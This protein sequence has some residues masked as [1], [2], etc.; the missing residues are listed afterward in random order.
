M[1]MA[2][3]FNHFDF[4]KDRKAGLPVSEEDMKS[5]NLF[6]VQMVLSMDNSYIDDINDINTTEF[7]RLPKK[8]QAQAFSSYNGKNIDTSWKK[9]KGSTVSKKE[10][11]LEKVMQVYDMSRNEAESCLLFKT[12]DLDE[13][14]E[15]YQLL[16][17]N[18][19]INFRKS[20]KKK[21]K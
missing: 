7:F 17:D 10:E 13:V 16:Y 9:S 20:R 6:M 3:N 5:I 21:A 4:M 12:V 8:I 14:E 11:T 2:N 15:L 1:V 19:S 18:K